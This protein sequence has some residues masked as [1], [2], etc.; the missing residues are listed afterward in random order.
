MEILRLQLHLTMFILLRISFNDFID[1]IHY[2]KNIYANTNL[3]LTG[4]IKSIQFTCTAHP[5]GFKFEY[6]DGRDLCF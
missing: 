1:S 2:F 6:L 5:F 4:A 3:G